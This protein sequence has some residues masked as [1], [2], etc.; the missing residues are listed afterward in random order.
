MLMEIAYDLTALGLHD[1]SRLCRAA[2]EGIARERLQT[3]TRP[4]Q[5]LSPLNGTNT[6]LVAN[7]PHPSPDAP[8][9]P[10]PGALLEL[11]SLKGQAMG[12]E[13]SGPTWQAANLV[14][15][16]VTARRWSLL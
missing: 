2:A 10:W 3:G 14:E 11:G 9:H 16:F 5:A 8:S 7:R 15:Q 4:L 13:S 1:F 6:V 12:G